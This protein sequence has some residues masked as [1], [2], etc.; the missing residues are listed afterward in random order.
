MIMKISFK[1]V[2]I[3]I[4]FFCAECLLAQQIFKDSDQQLGNSFSWHVKLGDLDKDGDLDAVVANSWDENQKNEIWLNNGDA[5]F[6]KSLQSLSSTSEVTLYDMN[7]DGHLDIIEHDWQ[8]NSMKVWINDGQV[9]FTQ[10]ENYPLK[11]NLICFDNKLGGL[12]QY[13]AITLERQ[14]STVLRIYSLNNNSILLRDSI[15]I[16]NIPAG[17]IAIG[18]LNNDGYSDIVLGN[19]GSTHGPSVILFNDKKDGFTKCK[20]ELGNSIASSV[21]LGDMNA[22]GFLDI[23]MCNY[24]TPDGMPFQIF[25]A[26]LYLNNSNGNFTE[27]PLPYNSSY[28]TPN[29]A[30]LDLDNDGD[31][32]IYLNHGHQYSGY[33]HKSDILYNDGFANFTSNMVDLEQIQSV[34]MAFDDLDKDGD[35]DI[36]LV[37]GD[38]TLIGRPNRVWLNTTIGN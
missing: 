23:L 21:Y 4:T 16:K 5:T 22:D 37:C 35:W 12:N 32:D 7:S 33:S 8:S 36:F 29:A 9:K 20:Q 17:C 11:G 2:G 38:L 28:I 1:I 19:S 34:S 18:D 15:I 31:L 13:E 24:H 25:P 3:M 30:I 27:K 14:D 10:S 6:I 26:K